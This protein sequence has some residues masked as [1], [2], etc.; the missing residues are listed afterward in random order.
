MEVPWGEVNR[1]QRP[2]S[3]DPSA[4][5]DSLPSLPVDG[6]PGFL[7]SVFTY[8][9]EPLGSVGRRYGVHGNTFVKVIEFGPRVRSGSVL[10]FGQSGDPE[11]PHYFDQAPLYAERR[12][13][14]AW[15][16]REEVETHAERRYELPR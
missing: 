11:S 4:L 10:V 9:T 6:A 8:Q 14:P 3:N 2:R 5:S 16:T 1:L 13:K 12:F 7:G 15:I